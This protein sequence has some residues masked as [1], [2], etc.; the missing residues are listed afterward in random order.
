M[1]TPLLMRSFAK[2]APKPPKS[3]TYVECGRDIARVVL[4]LP[5]AIVAAA[6]AYDTVKNKLK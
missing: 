6:V 1:I 5:L 2:K 3:Y 4:G